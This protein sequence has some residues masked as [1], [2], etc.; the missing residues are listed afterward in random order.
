MHPDCIEMIRYIKQK[1]MHC[2]MITNGSLL[3]TKGKALVESA[4]D[5][6]NISID[7]KGA[8]HDEIRGRSGLYEEV[9]A[10]ISAVTANK[11]ALRRSKPLINIQCTISKDNYTR[12]EELT[13]VASQVRADSL[14]FHHLIFMNSA[15]LEA[16]KRFDEELHCSSFSW[17]GFNFDPGIDAGALTIKLSQI[18]S[19]RYPFA[20]NVYPNF[21]LGL[22]KGYYDSS[23]QNSVQERCL[24]PWLAAYLFPDGIVRPCLNSTYSFGDLTRDSFCAVWNSDSAKRFRRALR[25]HKRFPVCMRCTELYRY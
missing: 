16:Q 18:L 24:S 6:L 1:K 3:R 15:T 20:V 17:E 23:S 12:L 7:G 11:H 14:T 22:L 9:V 2:L 25:A 13:Q 10:G 5:E 8:L 19:R 4:L 21:S